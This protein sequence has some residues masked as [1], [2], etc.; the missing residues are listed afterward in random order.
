[1]MDVLMEMEMEAV[2]RDDILVQRK[3]TFNT[4]VLGDFVLR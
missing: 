3:A 4:L 2:A 1:M